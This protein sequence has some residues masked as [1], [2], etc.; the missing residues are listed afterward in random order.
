MVWVS[1]VVNPVNA[2]GKE[3]AKKFSPTPSSASSSRSPAGSSLMRLWWRC[4]TPTPDC[5][6]QVGRHGRNSSPP[7]A[8]RSASLSRRV[9]KP[10]CSADGRCGR[11]STRALSHYGFRLQKSVNGARCLLLRTRKLD[12]MKAN[13]GAAAPRYQIT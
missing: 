10:A 2:S 1:L 11:T 3:Q 9:F 7:A 6:R 12:Q 13:L 4:I 8:P 5:R